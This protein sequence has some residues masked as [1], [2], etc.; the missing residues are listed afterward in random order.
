[1]KVTRIM[2]TPAAR[3]L[4][5][6][7]GIELASVV[8]SGHK[9]SIRA[10][11]IT[12]YKKVQKATPV[13]RNM[14]SYYNL[15]LNEHNQEGKIRKEDIERIMAT[16][17]PVVT[18]PQSITVEPTKR[19]AS[20]APITGMR[21]VIAERMSASLQTA[22]QYTLFCELDTTDLLGLLKESKFIYSKLSGNKLTFTDFL[23]K[24]T[25]LALSKHPAINSSIVE[26]TIITHSEINIGVAV[27]LDDGLIVPV[28]KNAGKL[29]LAEINKSGQDLFSRARIGKLLPDEFTGGTFTISNLGMYAVDFS[30]PIINQPESGILGVGRTVEKPV[31]IDG[32]IKIRSMT[33][34]SL[35]LD[36]RNIDG[37]VGAQFLNSMKELISNPL[38]ILA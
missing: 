16:M 22:P 33:G 12:S 4:A 6:E 15:N 13:A 17:T 29:S 10:R 36:H 2:A 1:M 37:A 25:A 14:A 35:T 34:F 23:V 5:G 32:E 26:N 31:V 18:V 19:T 21:K 8:G 30:T 20:G 9:G 38:C 3:R 27:S 24:I 11:D 7:K 28:I